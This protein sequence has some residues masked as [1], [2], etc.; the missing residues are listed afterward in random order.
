LLANGQLIPE[1]MNLGATEKAIRGTMEYEVVALNPTRRALIIAIDKYEGSALP[2]LKNASTDA[3]NLR[4]TLRS[5]GWDAEAELNLGLSQVNEAIDGFAKSVAASG[6]ACLLAYIGHGIEI[7]GNVFL[8]PS[9]CRIN[10]NR[11]EEGDLD[12][13][14]RLADV[15]AVFAAQRSSEASKRGS[16]LFL[17][18]CCRS[19]LEISAAVRTLLAGYGK[20]R[21]MLENS[22]TIFS[23][24]SGE[25]AEDGRPGEGGPWMNTF[26]T[27]LRETPGQD[28]RVVTMTT[29]REVGAIQLAQD[30]DSL[31]DALIIN[32]KSATDAPIA[33]S[34]KNSPARIAFGFDDDDA[35]AYQTRR[36][37]TR[38]LQ[39]WLQNSERNRMLVY[40]MG[41]TGKTT[42][43]KMFAAQAAAESLRDVVIFL[44]LPDGNFVD[45]YQQLVDVLAEP[46]RYTDVTNMKVE[47]LRRLVHGLL[48]SEKWRGHWLAVLDDLPDPQEESVAWLPQEFPFGF[49]KT[50]VTSRSQDWSKQGGPTKW[51]ALALQSMGVHEACEWVLRRVGAW[52]GRHAGVQELVERLGCLPLAVEHA[53]AF[54]TEFSIASPEEYMREH[55]LVV[56]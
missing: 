9:D 6:E 13:L 43:G 10:S 31:T 22:M 37:E 40:G 16:I 18:D 26:S 3:I 49:G 53:A 36:E 14:I 32:Q 48:R 23:T 50:L 41:G 52:E 38:S 39:A 25:T 4:D 47:D 29:R 56:C 34:R 11:V 51:D 24:S 35:T 33:G 7:G 12:R 5:L 54:S 17:L 21:T 42:L 15:Q 55:E 2:G 19:C 46:G 27:L 1:T 45:Q 28:V 20:T 8:L 44:T 30:E